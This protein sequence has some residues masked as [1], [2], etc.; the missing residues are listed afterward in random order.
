MNK[1]LL[2]FGIPILAIA[3]VSAYVI[4][5]T[6]T[7]FDIQEGQ[8]LEW[9]DGAV[10]VN[11]PLNVGNYDYPVET[12]N[13]GDSSLRQIHGVNPNNRAIEYQSVLTSPDP[14]VEIH[15]ECTQPG[16]Q[17]TEDIVGLVTTIKVL[18]PAGMTSEWGEL[19]IVDAAAP[20]AVDVQ[21]TGTHDRLEVESLAWLTC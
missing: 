21:V 3:L 15:F 7:H 19:T 17:Y 1:K 10:W 13:A 11:M 18:N 20:L 6:T 2:M 12:I 14:N 9:F 4:L 5:S 16:V 8:Q